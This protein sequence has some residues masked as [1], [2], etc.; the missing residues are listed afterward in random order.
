M[1]DGNG[2]SSRRVCALILRVLVTPFCILSD[3]EEITTKARYKQ[4][5]GNFIKMFFTAL[6]GTDN[7][8]TLDLINMNEL[9]RAQ[10][11]E[12]VGNSL[13]LILYYTTPTERARFPMALFSQPNRP[14]LTPPAPAAPATAPEEEEEP[15]RPA[16][17]PQQPPA[18]SV[19][20]TPV[21]APS[22]SVAA[23]TQENARL[24]QEVGRLKRKQQALQADLSQLQADYGA[25][26]RDAS[27]T[28]RSRSRRDRT[29]AAQAHDRIAQ[30]EQE[31]EACK[32]RHH[33]QLERFKQEYDLLYRSEQRLKAALADARAEIKAA[34]DR[35]RRRQP[36]ASPG[37]ATSTASR[38]SAAPRTSAAQ[39]RAPSA[40]RARPTSSGGLPARSALKKP[41]AP[42]ARSRS[43]TRSPQH[44]TKEKE[45]ERGGETSA[46]TGG[47]GGEAGAGKVSAAWRAALSSESDLAP[48]S[49]QKQ[50]RGSGRTQ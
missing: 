36:S 33:R 1:N 18:P 12:P 21:E 48:L 14:P 26:Q 17:P 27:A 30:L 32:S 43:T 45:K 16:S 10:K 25:L 28:Q 49:S 29:E 4:T 7:Q 9:A 13:S 38:R 41:A 15:R 40:S 24:Q 20:H 2:V 8:L 22:T 39:A 34:R 6:S 23:L 11:K 19:D 37:L 3:I 35:A 47:E 46:P 5:F 42:K 44:S 50:Q 31:L